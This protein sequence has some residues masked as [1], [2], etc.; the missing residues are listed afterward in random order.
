[1]RAVTSACERAEWARHCDTAMRDAGLRAGGARQAVVQLLARQDC[2]LSA[3]EI[4]DA[5]AAEPGPT[6][7]MA[8]VYRA[9]E[10][11][12]NLHLVHKVDL[13]GQV[14]KYEPAHPGGDHH[15]HA[16]C[17]ECGAVVPIEDDGVEMAIHAMAD[18]LAFDVEAHDITLRGR[19]ARCAGVR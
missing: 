2:C 1:M 4:H 10:T 18:R 13:G 11:L 5:L 14:A 16:V 17:R 12:T 9:L 15:H 8:S 3:H 6:P 19:C 7:G